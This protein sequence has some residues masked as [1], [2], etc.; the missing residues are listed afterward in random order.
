MNDIKC[1]YLFAKDKTYIYTDIWRD[2]DLA[3]INHI[4]KF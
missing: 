4:D 3:K 2:I 1:N